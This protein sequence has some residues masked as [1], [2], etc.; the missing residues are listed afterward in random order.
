MA[1]T[2]TIKV[3]PHARDRIN[4]RARS[5]GVTPSRFIESL[6]DEYDRAQRFAAVRAGYEALAADDDYRQETAGWDATL[7]DG[8]DDA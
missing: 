2:T 7:A 5:Q 6:V 1:A 4:E 3:T 8:L